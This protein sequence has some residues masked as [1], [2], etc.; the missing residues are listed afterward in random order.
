M[1]DHEVGTAIAATQ[2]NPM[3]AI[4]DNYPNAPE[5][6]VS[7]LSFSSQLSWTDDGAPSHYVGVP[8]AF[9]PNWDREALYAEFQPLVRRLIRQYGDDA[10]MRQDLAGEIFFRFCILLASYDPCRGVPLR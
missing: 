6:A 9:I 5:N 1:S 8:P 10:E 7:P 4:D 3:E 2:A